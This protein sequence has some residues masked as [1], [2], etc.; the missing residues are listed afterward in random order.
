MRRRTPLREIKQG[1]TNRGRV[2][3]VGCRLRVFRTFSVIKTSARGMNQF[4]NQVDQADALIVNATVRGSVSGD[5][6]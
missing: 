4:G 1:I 5:S 2:D 6:V 3:V